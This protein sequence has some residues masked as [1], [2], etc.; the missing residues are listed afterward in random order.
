MAVRNVSRQPRRSIL[1]AGA[2]AF[3]VL[4]ITLVQSFTGGLVDT[5]NARV[6][7]LLGGHVY[8]SGQEVSASGRLITVIRDQ[9]PLE[10]AIALAGETIESVHFRSTVAGEMIFASRIVTVTMN[11]VD[12]ANENPLMRSLDLI[13]GDAAALVD[14]RAILLPQ[15]TAQ[16]LGVEV[17]ESVLVRMTSVTGQ[18]GVGE[19]VVAGLI[20]GSGILGM[21][22]IYADRTYLNPLIGMSA[23]QYQQV[24]I[25]VTHTAAIEPVALAIDGHLASLG[26]TAPERVSGFGPDGEGRG[27]P[28]GPGGM[29]RGFN[30]GINIDAADRWAGTRFRVTTVNDVLEPVMTIVGILNQASIVLFVILLVITMVGLLNTFRMILIERTREIGTIRA[31]GM[32]QRQVRNLF[33][34]EALVLALGGAIAGLLLSL[35]AGLIIGA[36]PIGTQTPLVIFLDRGSFAFPVNPRGILMTLSILTTIT[37]VSAWVPARSAARLRPAD[38]LRTTY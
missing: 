14:P 37:L 30:F 12:W 16:E 7:E 36:I 25:A 19:F 1:L 5:A 2:I 26:M 33:L 27:P 3:G 35:V 21:A 20:R 18:Q 29:M 6:T 13:S 9:A 23:D 17:G 10:E 38:A 28:R 34:A 32:Q 24:V 11:G 22:P 15:P 4:I 8:V 31:V